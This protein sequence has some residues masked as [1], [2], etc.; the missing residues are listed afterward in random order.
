M[1]KFTMKP[2]TKDRNF[3]NQILYVLIFL[4]AD[5]ND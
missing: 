5:I 2:Q 3:L 4:K 1:K